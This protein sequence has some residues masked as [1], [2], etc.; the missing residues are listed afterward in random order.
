VSLAFAG[1]RFFARVELLLAEENENAGDEREERQKNGKASEVNAENA[2]QS[3]EDEVDG[4]EELSGGLDQF[5]GKEK[6]PAGK[7]RLAP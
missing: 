6:G 3:D 1:S 4:E 5:H 2:N 7:N